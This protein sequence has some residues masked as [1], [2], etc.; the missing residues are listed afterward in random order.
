MAQIQNFGFVAPVQEPDVHHPARPCGRSGQQRGQPACA[1]HALR[2][3]HHPAAHRQGPGS[4]LPVGN[5]HFQLADR[6][7]PA[8][9]VPAPPGIGASG[10]Q[11]L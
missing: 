7:V 9:Q 3:A 5:H 6:A 8:L 2:P 4:H 10:D 1:Q 11:L